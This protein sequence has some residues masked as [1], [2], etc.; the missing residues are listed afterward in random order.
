MRL[1]WPDEP[2]VRLGEILHRLTLHRERL[3]R[4]EDLLD[5]REDLALRFLLRFRLGDVWAHAGERICTP[6]QSRASEGV[7]GALVGLTARA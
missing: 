6:K 4:V 5:L 1:T 7:S 3:V 2:R